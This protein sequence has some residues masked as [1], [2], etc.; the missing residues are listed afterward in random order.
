MR[1]SEHA[2]VMGTMARQEAGAARRAGR[3]RV[4]CMPEQDALAGQLLQVRRR[5]VKSVRLN[6]SPGIVRMEIE[7]IGLTGG[8]G[9]DA[10]SR[11]GSAR[12]NALDPIAP[13]ISE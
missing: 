9:L 8:G 6:V 3:R 12:Q 4:K 5:N 13:G 7:D 2:I 10:I 1:Q 11:Q